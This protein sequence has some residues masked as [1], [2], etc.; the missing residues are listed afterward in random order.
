MSVKNQNNQPTLNPFARVSDFDLLHMETVN[1]NRMHK[2]PPM[3]EAVDIVASLELIRKELKRRG[4]PVP[5]CIH[6]GVEMWRTWDK[7]PVCGVCTFAGE[8]C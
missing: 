2:Y 4:L 3:E 6:C 8:P 1:I 5:K 7:E